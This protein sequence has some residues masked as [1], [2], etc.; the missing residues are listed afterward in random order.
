MLMQLCSCFLSPC[1]MKGKNIEDQIWLSQTTSTNEWFKFCN[2]YFILFNQL[3]IALPSESQK[4]IVEKCVWGV[5]VIK[6]IMPCIANALLLAISLYNEC[7]RFD[8]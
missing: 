5:G 2:M 3:K 4:T 6:G 7:R 1:A 8:G